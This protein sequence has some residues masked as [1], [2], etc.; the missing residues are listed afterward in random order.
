VARDAGAR[1]LT[2]AVIFDLDGVLVDSEQLWRDAE[3]ATFATVGVI[4]D[5]DLCR[6]TTGLRVDEVVGYWHRL[7]PWPPSRGTMEEVAAAIVR[8]VGEAMATAVVM[9]GAVAA[10][11]LCA[12]SGLRVA[13]ASSSPMALIEAAM[14]RLGV[15][16]LVDSWHSAENEEYG[17]PHPAV[18]MT[19]A[20]KLDVAPA[21]CLVVEDSLNGVIAAKAARM[22]CVAVPDRLLPGFAVADAVLPDL[23]A[24]SADLWEDP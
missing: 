13:I 1:S 20:A 2:E 19:A 9:P 7:W 11:R 6:Q 16:E 4:L 14:A 24:F 8:R 12:A 23:T 5:D 22:R 10:L 15:G 3:M 17:K 18:F 21:A